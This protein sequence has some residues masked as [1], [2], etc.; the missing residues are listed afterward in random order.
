MALPLH[1][2]ACTADTGLVRRLLGAGS[3]VDATSVFDR[4][5]ALHMACE[6]GR[7]ENARVLLEWG[8]DMH[9]STFLGD[10]P[11]HI[12]CAFGFGDIVR[13]LIESHAHMGMYNHDECTPLQVA[14]FESQRPDIAQMCVEHG[15]AAFHSLHQLVQMDIVRPSGPL[16][17]AWMNGDAAAFDLLSPVE[18]WV[19][20]SRFCGTKYFSRFV[21][22]RITYHRYS[23]CY[24][25]ALCARCRTLVQKIRSLAT[26]R[27]WPVPPHNRTLRPMSSDGYTTPPAKPPCTEPPALRRRREREDMTVAPTLTAARAQRAIEAGRL[28]VPDGMEGV[29][30]RIVDGE[31]WTTMGVADVIVTHTGDVV[32]HE[33]RHALFSPQGDTE[34]VLCLS[35]P[36]AWSLLELKR[37]LAFKFYLCEFSRTF[38]YV[39]TRSGAF[40]AVDSFDEVER[41]DVKAI[42]VYEERE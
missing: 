1:E 25:I 15:A 16:E 5:T 26:Q 37:L 22:K 14:L 9:A 40:G 35:V 7:I 31:K 4:T 11:L 17:D 41:D 29:A 21:M 10:T 12:A 19:V 20:L 23:A 33:G 13:A 32:V 27:G 6:S 28:Y 18:Q 38:V 2:A 3:P 8:A 39:L 30:R 42:F 34:Y 36:Q 24:S